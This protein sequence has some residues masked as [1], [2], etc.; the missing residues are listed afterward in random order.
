LYQAIKINSGIS[1]EIVESLEGVPAL[2]LGDRLLNTDV[3]AYAMRGFGD[4]TFI[5]H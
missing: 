4:D 2:G 1:C 5:P 3:P